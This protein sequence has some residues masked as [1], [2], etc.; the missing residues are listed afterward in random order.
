MTYR[1]RLARVAAVTAASSVTLPELLRR[2]STDHSTLGET[3]A[4][5]A[6]KLGGLF[7]WA[8]HHLA[9]TKGT[10]SDELVAAADR[11]RVQREPVLRRER[12]SLWLDS[13]I[14]SNWQAHQRVE[15]LMAS[16]PSTLETDLGNAR[17]LLRL[18]QA[19]PGPLAKAASAH[20]VAA[21][22]SVSRTEVSLPSEADG[23]SVGAGGFIE[24][25]SLL[26]LTPTHLERTSLDGVLLTALLGDDLE[27]AYASMVASWTKALFEGGLLQ[28]GLRRNTAVLTP[29]GVGSLR[30]AGTRRASRAVLDVAAQVITAPSSPHDASQAALEQ[31]ASTLASAWGS[32]RPLFGLADLALGVLPGRSSLGGSRLVGELAAAT[33]E[34]T[35]E[36]EDVLLLLRQMVNL[37]DVAE[38]LAPSAAIQPWEEVAEVLR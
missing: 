15:R 26:R 23:M 38:R 11:T 10:V 27:P 29:S 6:T 37:R 22:A 25:P 16:D 8:V 4:Q 21:S 1:A 5:Q 2:R 30:W 7:G 32:S 14:L 17:L 36:H 20:L 19:L 9:F 3:I 13:H 28:V 31:L 35:P 24:A 18:I 12:G 33:Q 34:S